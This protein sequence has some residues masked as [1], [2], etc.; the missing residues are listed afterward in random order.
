[1][2][3]IPVNTLYSITKRDSNRIDKVILRRISNA[4]EVDPAELLGLEAY[5]DPS[6]E[7]AYLSPEI[8][9]VNELLDEI[10][11]LDGF[12]GIGDILS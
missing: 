12:E 2:S 7:G 11:M 8:A 6:G 9:N 4:L 5:D 10:S 1:M 3:N